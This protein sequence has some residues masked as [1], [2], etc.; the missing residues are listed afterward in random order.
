MSWCGGG[1]DQADA[2]RGV[3]GLGDPRVDLVAGQLAALAGLGAL[4][5][6]DLDVVGVDQVL[7]GDTEAARG[8]L[9]DRAAPEIAVGVGHEARRGPRRPRRCSTWR[10]AG[11]WR[12]PASRGPRPRSSRSSSRRS[13]TACTIASTGS[14][15]SMRDRCAG[16]VSNRNSPR[17]VASCVGLVVD[18]GGVLLEDVVP[19]GAGGVLQL[20]DGLGVEEVVL[21]LAAPL[22]LAADLEVAMGPLV[23]SRAW[24]AG[25]AAGPPRGDRVE[26][27]AAECG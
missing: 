2:G 16:S 21:A 14:T 5:H 8:D 26:S 3:P 4:R 9:L 19:A 25:V 12:S 11:S 20:E 24:A 22:V 13:R 6:L 1:R 10:R 23:G 15:S 18:H 7:A 27:D 17:S